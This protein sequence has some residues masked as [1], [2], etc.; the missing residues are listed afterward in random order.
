M[1]GWG[2]KYTRAGLV[3]I[4]RVKRCASIIG[5]APATTGSAKN[6]A[7]TTGSRILPVLL[8]SFVR[9]SNGT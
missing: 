3:M 1:G 8:S 7:T 2:R 6:Q 4:R 5:G 9:G